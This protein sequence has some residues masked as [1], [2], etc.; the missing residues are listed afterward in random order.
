MSFTSPGDT[1]KHAVLKVG[2]LMPAVGDVLD[3]DHDAV[4]LP[5]DTDE[6]ARFLAERGAEFTVAVASGR[7]GVGTGLMRALPNLRAVV[8]FGVGYETTDVEQAAERGIGVSNTPDVLNDCVADTALALYLDVLR[9]ISAADR[10]VR[11]GHW[12]AKGNFPLTRQASNRAVGIVGLGRI[13]TVIARRLEAFNCTIAYHNRREVG[14]S[15]YEYVSSLQELARRSDVLIV[16]AAGGDESRHI[17]DAAV[18]EQLGPEGYLVNVA[19]GSLVDEAALVDAL[20]SGAIAGAGLDVFAE[21]PAVPQKLREL[22]NVVL[23]PHV[24]SATH[25]TRAAMAALTL[26]NLRKFL[27]DGA[28]ETPVVEPVAGK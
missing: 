19:R 26:A 17:I 24:G 27:A 5:S 6:Q 2:P 13:G 4:Q 8:S 3:Q 16:V 9:R 22:D 23:L 10:Y 14:G 15:P 20:A 12:E 11:R 1:T 28:L 21:E 18:L 7:V 25:E